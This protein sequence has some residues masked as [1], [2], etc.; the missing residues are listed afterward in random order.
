MLFGA[1]VGVYWHDRYVSKH[2]MVFL[3]HMIVL[4]FAL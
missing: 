4:F 3:G 2:D 1:S